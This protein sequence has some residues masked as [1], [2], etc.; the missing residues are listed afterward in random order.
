MGPGARTFPLPIGV[1]PI[2]LCRDSPQYQGRRASDIS[3]KTIKLANGKAEDHKHYY[4]A[5][6]TK[7]YYW[8]TMKTSKSSL[9]APQTA[10]ACCGKPIQYVTSA[11]QQYCSNACRSQANQAKR[12]AAQFAQMKVVPD[13][14]DT[15]ARN[16]PP[17]SNQPAVMTVSKPKA[18][19]KKSTTYSPETPAEQLCQLLEKALQDLAQTKAQNVRM[20]QE[21]RKFRRVTGNLYYMAG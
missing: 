16:L 7:I 14:G 8:E 1:M 17:G 3:E 20:E 13:Q 2:Y 19:A 10:C 18:P 5:I 11:V 21:L 6:I 15:Q 4:S 12:F 9:L